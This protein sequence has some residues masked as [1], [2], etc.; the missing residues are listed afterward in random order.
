VMLTSTGMGKVGQV[1]AVAVDATVRRGSIGS[2]PATDVAAKIRQL[3]EEK[4][5]AIQAAFFNAQET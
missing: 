5:D 3:R 4:S 2:S 1:G